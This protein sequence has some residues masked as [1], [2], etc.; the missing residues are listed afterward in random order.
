[1]SGQELALRS[2]IQALKF[3]GKFLAPCSVRSIRK[4]AVLC[5]DKT[6]HIVGAGN[7]AG[8][9]AMFLSHFASEVN[10]LVRGNTLEKSMSEH[11]W[12]RVEKNPKIRLRFTTEMESIEGDISIEAISLKNKTTGEVVCESTGGVFIYIA[13]HRVPISWQLTLPGT[14]KDLCWLAPKWRNTNPGRKIASLF[15][16]R[17]LILASLSPVI[18]APALPNASLLPLEM[19]HARSLAS[20]TIWEHTR[21]PSP[22]YLILR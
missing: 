5:Q 17:R 7:S 4:E 3:G 14:T 15:P 6:V 21:R 22:Q 9:A 12:S 19:E 20:M 18:V 10:V 8:Q 11:L 16:L 13:E 1:M 2:N